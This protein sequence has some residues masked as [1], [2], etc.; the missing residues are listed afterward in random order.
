MTWNLLSNIGESTVLLFLKTR[1][2]NSIEQTDLVSVLVCENANISC[3][4]KGLGKIADRSV[5]GHKRAPN[6]G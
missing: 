6:G 3:V 2:F 4:F 5:T 1:Q